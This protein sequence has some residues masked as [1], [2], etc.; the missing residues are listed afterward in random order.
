MLL[1]GGLHFF[2]GNTS[3]VRLLHEHK[4]GP[5]ARTGNEKRAFHLAA[6]QGPDAVTGLL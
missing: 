6:E 5:T 3:L 2:A 4:V 1:I